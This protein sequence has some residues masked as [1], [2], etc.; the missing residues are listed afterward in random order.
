M[1]RPIKEHGIWR[2]TI[3]INSRFKS[4]Y[5]KFFK[6]KY[7]SLSKYVED[8]LEHDMKNQIRNSK[9]VGKKGAHSNGSA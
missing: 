1:G 8:R 4:I 3:L 9:R 6:K 7:S 5:A 2:Y